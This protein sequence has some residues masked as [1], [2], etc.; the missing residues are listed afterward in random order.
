MADEDRKDERKNDDK[1]TVRLVKPVRVL[2]ET[3]SELKFR[4]PTSWDIDKIGDPFYYEGRAV[5]YNPSILI[6]MLCELGSYPPGTFGRQMKA[7]DLAQ[8]RFAMQGF[9]MPTSPG[10]TESEPTSD[11]SP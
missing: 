9:F 8:C 10:T 7:S 4:E 3:L 11:S 1:I 6:S 5:M 2:N